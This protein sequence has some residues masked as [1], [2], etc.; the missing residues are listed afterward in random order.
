MKKASIKSYYNLINKLKI[1]KKK[2]ALI[3]LFDIIMP[4]L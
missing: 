1:M 3:I 2:Y 4:Y